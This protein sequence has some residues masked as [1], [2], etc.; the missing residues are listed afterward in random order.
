MRVIEVA[1]RAVGDSSK[2]ITRDLERRECGVRETGAQPRS[3]V[4]ETTQLK[5]AF[6]VLRVFA[7]RFQRGLHGRRSVDP[8]T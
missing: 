7:A 4:Y 8:W 6:S 1:E 2:E 5:H 3:K